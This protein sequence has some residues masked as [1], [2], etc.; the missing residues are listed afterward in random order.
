MDSGYIPP[1]TNRHPV[2]P[3]PAG[4]LKT[5]PPRILVTGVKSQRPLDDAP[6]KS[7]RFRLASL[8]RGFRRPGQRADT[9]RALA[10]PPAP[11]QRGRT[12][13]GSPH[14]RQPLGHMVVVSDGSSLHSSDYGPPSLGRMTVL[15]P[16]LHSSDYSRSG[17]PVPL[18]PAG[19][20]SV[21]NSSLDSLTGIEVRQTHGIAELRP[22]LDETLSEHSVPTIGYN[23]ASPDV[24]AEG[25]GVHNSYVGGGDDRWLQ[26]DSE[27]LH[28]SASPETG[29]RRRRRPVTAPVYQEDGEA[30]LGPEDDPNKALLIET[31]Y[32]Q[33][34]RPGHHRNIYYSAYHDCITPSELPA[35][36][37]RAYARNISTT[38]FS[39]F[40]SY[41]THYGDLCAAQTDADLE[42][43]QARLEREWQLSATVLLA[44]VA[45][46]ATV[47]GFS[48]SGTLFTTNMVAR[49]CM[50]SSAIAGALGLIQV[51]GLLFL[52]L[53][54]SVQKFQNLALG[55]YSDYMFFAL[56]S[57][58]PL[59]AV[60]VSLIGLSVF[61]LATVFLAWPKA[62]IVAC[63][64]ATVLTSLQYIVKAVELIART[65]ISVARFI[66]VRTLAVNLLRK[67]RPAAVGT[68]THD[69]VV[70]V[71]QPECQ[72]DEVD[73][74]T[75]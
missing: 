34:E 71:P 44:V 70:P 42:V 54:A 75:I 52:Y 58:L 72:K 13:S 21:R 17:S 46:D 10:R 18:S 63:A 8:F 59:L 49:H 2:P 47:F 20:L 60:V 27:V 11:S 66:I 64:F 68:Q 55:V 1:S 41:L 31:P 39:I 43:V 12:R 35:V 3:Y 25:H 4:S 26:D 16:S 45:I 67:A 33:A 5:S 28:S 62:V 9:R 40:G 57:R 48:A 61:L 24:E 19:H 36:H 37:I 38:S 74:Y 50:A 23:L 22:P 32:T 56:T 7:L 30:S 14:P 73:P 6:V 15:N 69:A 65:L 53:G 51:A 29:L